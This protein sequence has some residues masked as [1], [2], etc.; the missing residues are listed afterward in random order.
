M[1]TTSLRGRLLWYELMTSDRDAAEA[2][3]APVVG[4]SPKRSA[5]PGMPP[6]TE[7][8]SPAGVPVGGAMALPPELV[9]GGV[10]PHW[11]MYVG[12]DRVED[13]AA[14]ATRLGGGELSP[15]IDIPGVGRMQTLRDPQGGAF[16]VYEPSQAPTQPEAPAEMAE[17]SW[18]ELYTTDSEAALRFYSELFGWQATESLDMDEAG[19]YRMFGRSAT[20]SLGGMMTKTA[21]MAQLPTAWLLYFRVDDIDAATARVKAAGGQ[22]MYG[23]MEV[24][25]GGFIVQALDPQGAAFALN[26]TSTPV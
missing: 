18:I 12:V 25:G 23:P 24:P 4:W 6:Y 22:V 14:H 19:V 9:A 8:L 13:A 3:Y 20:H 2:F 5:N 17:V 21:D 11:G 26:Q 16:S 1:T 10:P 7:W 15:V